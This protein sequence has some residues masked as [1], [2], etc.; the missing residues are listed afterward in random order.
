MIDFRKEW[1][2]QIIGYAE[3]V[4]DEDVIRKS[5]L[6]GDRSRTSVISPDELF[7][8]FFE[9][10]E[11]EA[12]KGI[13]HQHL[14]NDQRLC[15]AITRFIDAMSE[16]DAEATAA[17]PFPDPQVVL[18]SRTWKLAREAAGG[19]TKEADLAGYSSSDFDPGS[20]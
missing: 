9:S 2:P 19:L 3:L 18:D 7:V 1:L 13:L 14:P 17:S 5:W 12:Y 16:L 4:S 6:D 8:Q 20:R 10:L 11:A 15:E